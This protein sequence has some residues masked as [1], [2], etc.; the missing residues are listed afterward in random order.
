MHIR[1]IL[2]E[3]R[4]D[5]LVMR[6]HEVETPRWVHDE[7]FWF[8]ASKAFARLFVLELRMTARVAEYFAKVPYLLADRIVHHGLRPFC[9]IPFCCCDWDVLYY[10]ME[11]VVRSV[12]DIRTYR[13]GPIVLAVAAEDEHCLLYGDEP[14]P[15]PKFGF[16]FPPPPPREG[17]SLVEQMRTELARLGT[18]NKRGDEASR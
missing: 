12:T 10:P 16:G 11:P 9:D 5:D 8:I 15:T 14:W 2:S 17:P 3:E 6:R 13:S 7:D 1:R 18:D 4:R